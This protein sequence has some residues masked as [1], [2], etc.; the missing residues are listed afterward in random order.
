MRR[1]LLLLPGAAAP[2]HAAPE[3]ASDPLWSFTIPS[4]PTISDTLFVVE[5]QHHTLSV[6]SLN[7]PDN[8]RMRN[9][10]CGPALPVSSVR[11]CPHPYMWIFA[12]HPPSIYAFVAEPSRIRLRLLDESGEV[13]DVFSLPGLDPNIYGLWF[14]D[15]EGVGGKYSMEAYVDSAFAGAADIYEPRH[16]W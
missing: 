8:M 5:G 13:E 12:P 10:R 15:S 3:S 9:P 1:A 16:T 2:A 4:G 14:Q 11:F 6:R 7:L